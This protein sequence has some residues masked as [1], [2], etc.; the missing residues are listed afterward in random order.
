MRLQGLSTR[1]SLTPTNDGVPTD[2]HSSTGT[3]PSTHLLLKTLPF[4]TA[5]PSVSVE[6]VRALNMMAPSSW[7]QMGSAKF[8]FLLESEVA[9]SRLVRLLICL[10][11]WARSVDSMALRLAR[12]VGWATILVG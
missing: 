7:L 3:G 4:S 8:R 5:A 10:S 1:L 11:T 2:S 12:M 9:L 6:T